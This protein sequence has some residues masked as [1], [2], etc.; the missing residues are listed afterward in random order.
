MTEW[1]INAVASR[2]IEAART[3]ERLAPV[4]VEGHFNVWPPFVR[5]ETEALSAEDPPL[6]RFH[7]S[8]AEIERMLVVMHWVQWL[9]IEQR[10]LV[11]MRAEKYR[12]KEIAKRFGFV[13][14]T[15]KRHWHL[16]MHTVVCRLSA[17]N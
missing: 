17:E 6:P 8:P 2:F 1:S 10:H 3:A 15:A 16:A 7:P 9:E 4:R 11:W 12:W 5:T 14:R 13:P